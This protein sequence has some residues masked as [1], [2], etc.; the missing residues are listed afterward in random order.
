MARL[1]GNEVSPNRDKEDRLRHGDA[2]TMTYQRRA[3][4]GR[5]AQ[6]VPPR[7][8]GAR[9]RERVVVAR[10][11]R[12]VV[13]ATVRGGGDGGSG[14][15]PTVSR[16]RPVHSSFRHSAGG[17]ALSRG[18]E[19]YC[20]GTSSQAH[21]PAVT[22]GS[23]VAT[24]G[25][26]A[27]ILVV[28]AFARPRAPLPVGAVAAGGGV[29]AAAVATAAATVGGSGPVATAAATVGG[30]GPVAAATADDASGEREPICEAAVHLAVNQRRH[31]T[32]D[33]VWGSDPDV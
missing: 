6:P 26:A 17:G 7:H 27:A 20:W 19:A 14:G 11:Q 18:E 25:V 9:A 8:A 13:E 2:A 1:V 3:P 24:G 33:A 28:S 31:S 32:Q 12:T 23:V 10:W 30:S 29:A 15:A 4:R 21:G 22:T 5:R 16:A